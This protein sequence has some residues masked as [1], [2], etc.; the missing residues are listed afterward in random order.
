MNNDF[1]FT[2]KLD[3][4]PT[5]AQCDALFDA[6]L[7]DGNVDDGPL[8]ASV[9]VTRA[10]ANLD[11]AILS[12]VAQIKSVGL[13]PT[14]IM[15]ED[16]VTLPVIARRTGRTHESVR[17]LAAG[18]RGPGNFPPPLTGALYSWAQVR[19]W[20]ATYEGAQPAYG[21]EE[22]TLAAADLFLRANILR[23]HAGKLTDLITA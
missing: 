15:N 22:D 6:G 2:V 19:N 4:S 16:L 17:L 23:P 9:I 20:F 8:G 11:D 5:D 14:G 18:K 21:T 7:D 1:T 12:V 13:Q 10:A 3:R